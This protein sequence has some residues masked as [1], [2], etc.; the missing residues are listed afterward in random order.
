MS[1][2]KKKIEITW[3]D[4]NIVG[5]LYIYIIKQDCIANTFHNSP[6]KQSAQILPL[7]E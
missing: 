4:I 7:W 6:L 2:R 5:Y 1:D 3:S